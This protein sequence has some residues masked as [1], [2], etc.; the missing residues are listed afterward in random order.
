MEFK[1]NHCNKI[2]SSYQ[3][4]SNHIR[5]YHKIKIIQ[6]SSN[7]IKIHPKIIQNSS[8]KKEEDN[9]YKCRTCDKTYKFSQGR[10]KHEKKCKNKSDIQELKDKV[11]QLEKII[12][13]SNNKKIINKTI[14]NINNGTINNIQVNA[15][16]LENINDKL[17]ENEKLDLLSCLLFKEVPVVE[18][19]RK[20]Y[21]NEKFIEDRNTIISNLQTKSCLIY[22]KESNKFEA[23]NKNIHI[24]NIIDYR[25]KDIKELYEEMHDNKKIKNSSRKLIEEYIEKSDTIKNTEAY[26]KYKE[27]IIYII[28]NCKDF[29]KKYLTC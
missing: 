2:Y 18:M 17:N 27:E 25:N 13:T 3:S 12:N 19:I 7:V 29:M 23:T 1:C 14:N 6:N 4:R 11:T 21:N 24:D 10:W 9:K 16:G 22:N 20:I 15:L 8:D 28:Y 5:I 26:K